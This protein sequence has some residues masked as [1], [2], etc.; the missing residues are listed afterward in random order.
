MT[1]SA[2]DSSEPRPTTSPHDP[3]SN[4]D[5]IGWGCVLVFL[6]I[7]WTVMKFTDFTSVYLRFSRGFH[8]YALVYVFGSVCVVL[9]S[10][11]ALITEL[12]LKTVNGDRTVGDLR[13]ILFPV[14]CVFAVSVVISALFESQIANCLESCQDSVRSRRERRSQSQQKPNKEETL[15]MMSRGDQEQTQPE[16]VMVSQT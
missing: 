7:L 15:E 8:R 4:T 2:D 12:I 5:P 10:S 3:H 13:F 6:Q 16:S 1:P 9:L 14:E 11:A